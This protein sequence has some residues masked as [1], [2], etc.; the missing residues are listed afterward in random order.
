VLPEWGGR[1]GLLE[2]SVPGSQQFTAEPAYS[3]NVWDENVHCTAFVNRAGCGT[4]G[5]SECLCCIVW[6]PP[7]A[8][9]RGGDLGL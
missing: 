8:N 4:W 6:Q 2:P 7:G 3:G 1:E 5:L 9:T